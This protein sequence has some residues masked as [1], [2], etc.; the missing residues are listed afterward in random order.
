MRGR[1]DKGLEIA[2]VK[3]MDRTNPADLEKEPV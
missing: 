2:F 3:L 1:D